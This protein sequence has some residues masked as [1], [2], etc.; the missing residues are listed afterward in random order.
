MYFDA[1]GKMNTEQTIALAVARG[2]ELGINYYVVASNTGETAFQLAKTGVKTVC[3]THHTG[4][5]KPGD[6]EMAPEDRQKL[7]EMG[8]SVLTTTHLFGGIDRAL[9]N[10]FGGWHPAGIVAYTLKLFGQGVKVAVEVAVMALDAGLIP[11]GE[12]VVAIG[13]SGRGADAAIVIRPAHAKNF[14]DTEI[15][16][17]IC[18]PRNIK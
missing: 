9:E 16:E 17:I 8:V 1:K 13:G 5:R 14:F 6:Q 15:K 7:Q 11:Y 18:K 2:K 3:V 12:D 4:F 10:R